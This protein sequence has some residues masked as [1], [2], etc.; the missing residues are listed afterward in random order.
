MT[1]SQLT[2]GTR[3]TP[4]ENGFLVERHGYEVEMIAN[5]V[6][7]VIM[8]R[9]LITYNDIRALHYYA[10]KKPGTDRRQV[11]VANL[12]VGR[13]RKLRTNA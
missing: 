13:L 3:I 6:D 11:V 4:T 12:E 1:T 10:Q 2:D 7:G 9:R 8:A 5:S